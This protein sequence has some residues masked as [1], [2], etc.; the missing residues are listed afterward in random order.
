MVLKYVD[1]SSKDPPYFQNVRRFAGGRRL[2]V[3]H[4]VINNT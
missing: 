2:V 4:G 1:K 3:Y